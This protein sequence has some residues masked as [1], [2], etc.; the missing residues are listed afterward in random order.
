MVI[1]DENNPN[2]NKLTSFQG[3][4]RFSRRFGMEYGRDITRSDMYFLS[5]LNGSRVRDGQ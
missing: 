2:L 1:T 5:L 3:N 4:L